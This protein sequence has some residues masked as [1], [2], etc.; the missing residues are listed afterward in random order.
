MSPDVMTVRLHLRR[1]RVVA[2]LVDLVDRLVVEISDL[3]RVVRCPH[4]GFKTS[5]VHDRRSYRVHDLGSQGRETTLVW[6]RRRS[7]VPTATNGLLI[8]ISNSSRSLCSF[9]A[10]ER[11]RER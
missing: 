4:C 11:S 7:C 1:I 3:R 2:V 9:K 5:S 6:S 8:R 10:V